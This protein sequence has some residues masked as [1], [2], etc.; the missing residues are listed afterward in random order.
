MDLAAAVKGLAI[1]PGTQVTPAGWLPAG[2][3]RG[4]DSQPQRNWR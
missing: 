1:R 2:V 4:P 3:G